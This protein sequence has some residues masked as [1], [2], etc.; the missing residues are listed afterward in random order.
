[1]KIIIS[2]NKKYKGYAILIIFFSLM[3]K[4]ILYIGNLF[5]YYNKQPKRAQS[6]TQVLSSQSGIDFCEDHFSR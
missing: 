3:E 2:G 5:Q 4:T 6:R 1:M